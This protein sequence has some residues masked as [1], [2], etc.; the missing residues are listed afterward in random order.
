MTRP[1]ARAAGA[2]LLASLCSALAG[3]GA[4]Q[5]F[6]PPPAHTIDPGGLQVTPTA[7]SMSPGSVTTILATEN[8]YQ[9]NFGE[10]DDCSGVATVS[11][12]VGGS[13][14]VD[15]V[16]AGTCSIT[17]SDS[18][19]HSQDIPVSIQSVIIGGQ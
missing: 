11:Q 16:A 6:A 4:P 3:C 14:S 8:R 15:A 12:T 17:I 1:T 13:F 18:N 2:I 5:G 10:K 7:V 9:G 19:G